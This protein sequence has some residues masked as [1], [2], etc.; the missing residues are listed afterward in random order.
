MITDRPYQSE[1]VQSIFSYF[2][3]NAGHPLIAMPTG[4]GKSV[5]LARFIQAV[6][7]QYP[8]QRVMMLTHVKEL[9]EQNFEKLL[10]VWPSAPAGIYS[11]GLGKKEHQFPITFAGIGSVAKRAALFGKINLIIIDE[12]HLVSPND[13]TMYRSF[14]AELQ[15][16]N[17]ALKVIGMTATPWRI[18]QG[19]LVNEGG[20]FTDVCF[21]ITGIEAFQ[22]LIVEG[23]LMPLIPRPMK[24]TIDTSTLHLRG[25]EF[26]QAE[27]QMAVDKEE[28]TEAAIL[29][30]IAIAGD[31]KHWLIFAA[32]VEHAIHVADRLKDFGINAEA[33]Y[34]GSKEHPLSDK[35]RDRRIADFKTGKLQ[36]LVNNNV[37]TTGFDC[38]SID[39][40]VMLRPTASIVLWVQMLGRG[41]RPVYAPGYDLAT[42]EGRLASIAAGPKKNCMVLD[43]AGNTR[44]LG[45]INDPV[46]P[47]KKGKGGG[48]A[49]I[50][51]CGRCETLNHASARYC[52]YCGEEFHF[53]TKITTSSSTQD[54]IKGD[55]PQVE[56]FPVSHVEYESHQKHG[57]PTS[58]KV[59]YYCGLRK[60]SEYVCLEHE[61]NVQNKARRWWRDATMG[62]DVPMTVA[63]AITRSKEIRAP[64]TIR[65]W[66]NK[67]YP[68]IMARMYAEVEA[69]VCSN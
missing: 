51:E 7:S 69:D 28:I 31:R 52:I 24:T 65:V 22:R 37:L 10:N 33:V 12:A 8:S 16:I 21:D 38:P 62:A 32:G 68:E 6:Y 20:L 15:E 67:Q 55:L 27:V 42:L 64:A 60:F 58:L 59:T 48:D 29:E 53:Q 34:S 49:P 45:P 1:A 46:I 2:Y 23:Y 35:E 56:V 44:R 17:P 36:A 57:R 11:A 40:I 19:N 66:I 50:K 30:T 13:E 18:G 61:G 47:K 3:Q 4:T 39:L 26:V 63:N 43:F 5:V 9:I 14:I 54:L 25:G 41:T